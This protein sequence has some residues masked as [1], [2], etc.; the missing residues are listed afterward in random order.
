MV[1]VIVS[2]GTGPVQ[3]N[4]GEALLRGAGAAAAK[5]APLLSVSAQPWLFLIAANIELNAGVAAAP[6]KQ[7]D[8]PYHTKSISP[9]GPSVAAVVPVT[10]AT[11]PLVPLMAIAGAAT[12]SGVGI[13]EPTVPAV[14]ICT[15]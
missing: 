3:E 2:V 15:R 10:M 12:A 5:S 13:G 8:A 11:L 7:V 9:A 14:L 6:S 4:A 1:P